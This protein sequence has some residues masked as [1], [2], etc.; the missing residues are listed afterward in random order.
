LINEAMIREDWSAKGFTLIEL[1]ITISLMGMI[2]LAITA[3][4]LGSRRFLNTANYE[5]QVQSEAS[6][7]LERMVKEITLAYGQS[8]NPG[9][10]IT[11][12][13]QITIRRLDDP[14][15]TYAD[16]D[17]DPRLRYTFNSSNFYIIRET[18]SSC[19]GGVCSWNPAEVIAR[20][21]E[22]GAFSQ[23]TDG[24]VGINMTAR[25]N[26][27]ATPPPDTFENPRVTL[28]TSVSPRSTS[29]N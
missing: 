17:D 19:P 15:P 5:A 7:A 13:N 14:P 8:D 4:D 11:G 28:E 6:P 27:Q 20:N 1:L 26:A 10:N 29:L 16:F 12:S 3:I 9:I 18:S 23:G 25:R 21:I 24:V 22:S 2:I